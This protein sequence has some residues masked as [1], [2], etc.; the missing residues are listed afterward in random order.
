MNSRKRIAVSIWLFVFVVL[1][2]VAGFKI[3]GGPEWT[4][5]DAAYMT[6]ITVAT[7]GY[8]EVHDLAGNPAARVFAAAY[9]VLSLGTIAF[10]VTSITAFVVEGELKRMLGRRRMDKDIGRLSGHD[11]VCGSDETAQTIIDE[12]RSTKRA[13]VVVDASAERLEKI[14]A[15]G[16][17]LYVVGDPADDAVLV[18]AGIER[19]RGLLLSLPTDEANLF[20]T[21]SAR[22]LNPKLRIVAK[23][24]DVRAHAKLKKAGADYV[25]SPTFIGGMRM[26]SEMVRPA[27][28]SFLDTM[29]RDRGANLRVEDV[30]VPLESPFAGRTV[31]ASGLRDRPDCLLVAVKRGGRENDYV[32]NPAPGVMVEAGDALVFI[33]PA[34]AAA[35]VRRLAAGPGKSA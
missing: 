18:Q 27:A 34:E 11:I 33:A 20:V 24:I 26:V 17:A 15:A 12:L 35:D 19:A 32:F 1:I 14:A 7:I 16:G 3:L 6:V 4:L 23:G 2:G 25:V 22:G 13:F 5:L 10:A 21:I 30:P 28:V 8:G 29:L 9:I 31:G